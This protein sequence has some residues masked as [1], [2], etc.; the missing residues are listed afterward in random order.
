M[1]TWLQECG[2]I[3]NTQMDCANDFVF[4]MTFNPTDM[5]IP[6]MEDYSFSPNDR[7]LT[8][9]NYGSAG[10]EPV[11]GGIIAINPYACSGFLNEFFYKLDES[12]LHCQPNALTLL[13]N[14]DLVCTTPTTE[15]ELSEA[16][17]DDKSYVVSFPPIIITATV[18]TGT[19]ATHPQI[20]RS[21]SS[22]ATTALSSVSRPHLRRRTPSRQRPMCHSRR[23]W[24]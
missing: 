23:S 5:T 3:N 6:V 11:G 18:N 13:T 8:Y 2:S 10:T 22:S 24:S 9:L 15:E 19:V 12:N 21:S 1:V 20:S 4:V 16:L 17:A 7:F 14:P